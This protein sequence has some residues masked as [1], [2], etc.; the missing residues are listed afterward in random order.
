MFVKASGQ[1]FEDE[2][3]ALTK[4]GPIARSLWIPLLLVGILQALAGTR[5][6]LFRD[7]LYYL[8]CADRLDWAYV[9]HPGLSVW[10][11]RAVTQIFGDADWVVRSLSGVLALGSVYAMGFLTARLGGSRRAVALA[12]LVVAAAPVYRVL[13]LFYSPNTLELMAWIVVIL[14]WRW[15]LEP[16]ARGSSWIWLG[17]A[18]G[19]ASENRLSTPWLLVALFVATVLANRRT[20]WWGPLAAGVT[21]LALLSPWLLWQWNHHLLTL[22]FIRNANSA[23]LVPIGPWQFVATQ[24]VVLNVFAAP[25]WLGAFSQWKQRSEWRPMLAAF[26]TVAAILILNGRSRENYLSPA[27]AFVVPL[28][29]I[30]LAERLGRWY[31]GYSVLLVASGAISALVCMPMLPPELLAE[32]IHQLPNPPSVEK[33]E[34][35]ELQGLGDTIGWPEQVSEVARI[36]RTLPPGTPIFAYNYGEAS[37]ILRYGPR[38]GLP[39]PICGHNN[40]WLWSHPAWTGTTAVLVGRWPASITEQFESVVLV[41]H[42]PIHYAVPEERDVTIRVARGFQGDP[43][44]LGQAI[45]VIQ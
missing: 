35:G 22:E 31:K 27:Y 10:L 32:L 34:K 2:T 40:F 43:A 24:L 29:S 3:Q 44:R 42:A 1:S 6:G 39:A 26:L 5:Y 21:S 25:V 36:W 15:C 38:L 13:G 4:A 33:G 14:A 37:A 9:D 16:D 23:K 7:E 20:L 45:R 18:F 30:W 41:P 28:G 19:L 11:L 8:A 12:G 17:V